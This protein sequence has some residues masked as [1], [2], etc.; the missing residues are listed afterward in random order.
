MT[1]RRFGGKVAAEIGLVNFSV[2]LA[3][4]REETTKV[5]RDIAAKD[6]HAL[7]ATKDAY[8]FSLEMTWEASMNYT[9]AKEIELHHAQEVGWMDEGV[10]DFVKGKFKPGLE[11]HETIK[12]RKA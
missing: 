6:P 12:N 10:G 8:R 4:L 11:S 5:A 7:R 3:Q 1:G 2:P 9:G